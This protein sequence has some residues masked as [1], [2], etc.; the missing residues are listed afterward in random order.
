MPDLNARV[1]HY[2]PLLLLM[3]WMGTYTQL[4]FFGHQR[5][6]CADPGAK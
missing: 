6:I 3:I 1:G 5:A 4:S 2:L